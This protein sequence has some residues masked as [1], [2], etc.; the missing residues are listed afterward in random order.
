MVKA[1]EGPEDLSPG[2]QARPATRRSSHL[3]GLSLPLSSF[4][5]VFLLR[6]SFCFAAPLPCRVALV[7]RDG[8]VRADP[9][10]WR[11]PETFKPNE[12]CLDAP[13]LTS[14]TFTPSRL[15]SVLVRQDDLI[16]ALVDVKLLL[17]NFSIS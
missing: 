5:N 6:F 11:R 2:L 9:I 4:L 3:E 10:L 14:S 1:M 17:C 7:R 15:E 13:E 8:R 16:G 12:S